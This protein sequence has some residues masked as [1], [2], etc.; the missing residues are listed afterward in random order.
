VNDEGNLDMI[1]MSYSIMRL[2]DE[3]VILD[4]ATSMAD[5]GISGFDAGILDAEYRAL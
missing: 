4:P 2:Q 3:R 5:V 1:G